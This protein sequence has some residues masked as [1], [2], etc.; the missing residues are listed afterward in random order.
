MR[1]SPAL[2]GNH[3]TFPG[4]ASSLRL[5]PDCPSKTQARCLATAADNQPAADNQQQAHARPPSLHLAPAPVNPS[6]PL[7]VPVKH[8]VSPSSVDFVCEHD[9]DP[10]VASL[11]NPSFGSCYL[12][13]PWLFCCCLSRATV[14]LLE[15]QHVSLPFSPF[16]ARPSLSLF[17][18]ESCPASWRCR[19]GSSRRQ[20]A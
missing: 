6:R 7:G 8:R 16:F 9:F 1:L 15:S 2:S 18:G 4:F 14:S 19:S 11:V 3:P 17:V 20:S 13:L 12:L 5:V 10:D